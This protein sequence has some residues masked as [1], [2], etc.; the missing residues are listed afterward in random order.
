MLYDFIVLVFFLTDNCFD[1]SLPKIVSFQ[2]FLI[3]RN[4]MR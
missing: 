4:Y 2:S 1:F 3:P